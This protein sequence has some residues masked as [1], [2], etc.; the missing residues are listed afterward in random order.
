MKNIL[1]HL[2]F[3]VK[4]MLYLKLTCLLLD[5]KREKEILLSVNCFKKPST[6]EIQ[7][8]TFLHHYSTEQ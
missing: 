4:T 7:L 2:A 5:E 6:K 1:L 8:I 3:S